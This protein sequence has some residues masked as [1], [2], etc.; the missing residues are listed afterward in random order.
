MKD[1]CVKITKGNKEIVKDWF[2]TIDRNTDYYAWTEGA[3]Y[4]LKDGQPYKHSHIPINEVLST[5]DF[6]IQIAYV[7]QTENYPIF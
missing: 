7:D 3:Y 2:R 4:G 1:F 5:S 6:L